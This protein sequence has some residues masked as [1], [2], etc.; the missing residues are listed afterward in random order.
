M[1][2]LLNK[3]IH[4]TILLLYFI[5]SFIFVATAQNSSRKKKW[6]SLQNLISQTDSI[7]LKISYY[8]SLGRLVSR[9]EK[10][11]YL[12]CLFAIRDLY[13]QDE[14]IEKYCSYTQHI[15]WFYTVKIE[16]LDS[17]KV[18]L[19]EGL[20]LAE[21]LNDTML[22]GKGL[23]Y[24]GLMYQRKG[25]NKLAMT[26]LLKSLPYKMALGELNRIAFS[27]NLIGEVY[28]SQQ[29]YHQGLNY[30]FKALELRKKLGDN[31]FHIG[32]SYV[33]ISGSY[34]GNKQYQLALDYGLKAL[35][36]YK[37]IGTGHNISRSNNLVGKAY[38]KLNEI[39]KAILYFQET[40]KLHDEIKINFLKIEA[41][42]GLAE[43]YLKKDDL[44][45][46][47]KHA[48]E[49]VTLAEKH[50][51]ANIKRDS[52]YILSE[53]KKT[54]K[55][56]KEAL[57]YYQKYITS[58][59]SITNARKVT[60][61]A[62]MERLYN[63]E[64]KENEIATLAAKNTK[65]QQLT[66]EKKYERNLALLIASVILLLSALLY[67]YYKKTKQKNKLLAIALEDRNVLLKETH[68]RIKNSF[69]MV[70][71]LLF[72]QAENI[73]D[74]KASQAVREGQNRVKSMALIHQK[75]YQ[76]DNLIGVDTK[77]YI[78]ELINDIFE[79]YRINK[80]KINLKTAIDNIALD[81]ENV[82]AIGLII[83]E[84]LTNIVK[85]AF[86][87]ESSL[88]LIE[89]EFKDRIDY[90]ELMVRDNGVG[91]D[92]EAIEEKSF[93]IKLIK[94]LGRKLKAETEFITDNGTEVKIKMYNYKMV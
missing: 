10:H 63:I 93:G 74:E 27:Y 87:E 78:E 35:K 81:I 68:H 66:E 45:E 19:D 88:N 18:F 52:Y 48:L 21:K 40:V 9:N 49:S 50:T 67:F 17:A 80:K 57:E 79:T 31:G 5:S 44:K 16:A 13:K 62:E 29:Q 46:A 61:I 30:H 71:S 4:V 84:L 33:N 42:S 38:L 2:Y 77:E 14:N 36:I 76:K 73:E 7:H 32:N 8:E 28:N 82:M 72:L 11:K 83:N 91:F 86:T 75:L 3:K 26:Y 54:S 25:Y 56:Y 47:E 20:K 92:I 55:N 23:T 59:D 12:Q 85:H 41:L 69:Q 15:G 1:L 94:S 24:T 34:Y 22:I 6:D 64:K 60:Q 89:V 37:K 43:A 70:S 58:K 90:L 51:Y 53:L 39:D 65:Q